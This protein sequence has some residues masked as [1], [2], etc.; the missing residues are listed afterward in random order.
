MTSS[1]ITRPLLVKHLS[2]CGYNAF[3][4]RYVSVEG[5]N[6]P[7][8]VTVDLA[9]VSLVNHPVVHAVMVAVT[10]SEVGGAV[11]RMLRVRDERVANALWLGVPFEVSEA[12]GKP[13][14]LEKNGLGLIVVKAQSS[15]GLGTAGVIVELYPRIEAR[16]TRWEALE[17]KLK[18]K[19]KDDLVAELE[20]TLGKKPKV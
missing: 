8:G 2:I 14:T 18:E 11:E 3:G 20:K 6:T 9:P 5:V 19:G 13:K 10:F 7:G 12:M 16:K 17:E 15:F 4:E 1:S